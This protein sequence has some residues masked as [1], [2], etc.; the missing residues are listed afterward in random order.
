MNQTSIDIKD[1][2]GGDQHL[3]AVNV[4]PTSQT[5]LIPASTP[6]DPNGLPL[7]S[8]TNPGANADIIK[9]ITGPVMQRPANVTAYA[10]GQLIANSLGVGGV[11]PI[12]LPVFR[13]LGSR[14]RLRRARLTKS[15][16][17]TTNAI[18]RAHI[19][20]DAPTMG[21]VVDGSALAIIG[22]SAYVGSFTFDFTNQTAAP[23]IFTDGVKC[24]ATP[25]VGVD[26]NCGNGPGT[27]PNVY[28][29]LEARAAYAPANQENFT[30]ALELV[31]S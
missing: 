3:V 20:N 2:L 31:Q 11:V 6:F 9:A 12:A 17:L 24:I 5:L 1:G 10:S 14:V 8:D 4:G 27:S 19:F 30:L 15:A 26:I 21:T 25:D 7:F 28:A 16:V 22:V 23:A 29:L 18:I 13:A